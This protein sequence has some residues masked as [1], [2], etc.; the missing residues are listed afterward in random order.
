[1][2]GDPDIIHLVISGTA[3]TDIVKAG[4]IALTVVL[5]VL[6][7][8]GYPGSWMIRRGR[9][10]ARGRRCRVRAGA[11]VALRLA[12]V[13]PWYDALGGRCCPWSPWCPPR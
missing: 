2:A 7:I 1:V 11:R 12:Y 4:A 6:L 3:A 8:R 10:W 9:R 13:L 5:A